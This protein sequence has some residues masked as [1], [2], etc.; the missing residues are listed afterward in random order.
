MSFSPSKFINPVVN[1]MP[2]S[3]IRK[4]FDV[5]ETMDNVISL[6]IGEPD[7]ITPWHIRNA[8]IESLKSGKTQY[9]S[10]SGTPELKKEI[11]AYLSRRFNL[12]YDH[13]KQVIITVGGSEAIDLCIRALISPGD[14]VIIPIPSFVCYAPIV[15]LTGGVPVYVHLRAGIA[16]FYPF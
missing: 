7:F 3:G 2:P 15:S 12:T 4:L 9:T 16:G 10:N 13:A 5:A 14:E 11:S 6:G 1:A 8:G